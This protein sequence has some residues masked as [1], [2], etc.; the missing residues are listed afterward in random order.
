MNFYLVISTCKKILFK[1]KIDI[2]DFQNVGNLHSHTE[3]VLH[4]ITFSAHRLA[5]PNTYMCQ[6]EV[7]YLITHM[8]SVGEN[9]TGGDLFLSFSSPVEHRLLFPRQQKQKGKISWESR[10]VMLKI[11]I[12]FF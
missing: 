10:V 3:A 4:A 9:E 6:T 2:T 1:K 12:F 8:L 11:F 7:K 5:Y